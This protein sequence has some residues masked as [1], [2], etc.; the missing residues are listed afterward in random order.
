MI[1]ILYISDCCGEYLC[2]EHIAYEI[3][4]RCKEHCEIITEDY[5]VVPS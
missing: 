4:P 2:D 5:T 3:C 1:E